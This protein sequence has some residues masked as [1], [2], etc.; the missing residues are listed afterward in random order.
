MHPDPEY[1]LPDTWYRSRSRIP[2]PYPDP[3][4][5]AAVVLSNRPTKRPTLKS[6]PRRSATG[7]L[8]RFAA[9]DQR[10]SAAS[11]PEAEEISTRHLRGRSEKSKCSVIIAAKSAKWGAVNAAQFT[12]RSPMPA[13][14]LYAFCFFSKVFQPS[15]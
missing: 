14:L 4:A 7:V 5:P 15:N 3:G 12:L 8:L 1:P 6:T 2:E 10:N 13:G 9:N 11:S